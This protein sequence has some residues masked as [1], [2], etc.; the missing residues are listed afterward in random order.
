MIVGYGLLVSQPTMAL[1]TTADHVANL[2][3]AMQ[4]YTSSHAAGAVAEVSMEV[5]PS[6]F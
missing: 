1:R 5:S 4:H 3:Q 6:G 2:R